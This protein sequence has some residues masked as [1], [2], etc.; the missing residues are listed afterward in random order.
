[1]AEFLRIKRRGERCPET[2]T[3]TGAPEDSALVCDLNPDHPGPLHYDD[4]DQV[5][6]AADR[7]VSRG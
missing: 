3:V 4:T 5:W 6:W 1:M 2:A 7:A